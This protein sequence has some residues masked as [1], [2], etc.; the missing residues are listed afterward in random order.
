MPNADGGL[1]ARSGEGFWQRLKPALVRAEGEYS[2]VKGLTILSVF[3]TLIGAYFQNLSA[4]ESKVAAQAQADLTAATQVFAETSSALAAPLSLQKQL[5][6]DYHNAIVAGT[7]GEAS[8]Y[9]TAHAHEI[10]KAYTKAYADLSQNYN[11]LARKAEL[12]IDLASDLRRNPTSDGTPSSDEID[13]SR[14]N[15]YGFDCETHM[16]SFERGAR[17]RNGRQENNSQEN[18]SKVILTDAATK[19]TLTVDWYSAKHQVLAI[20]TCFEITHQA[21][22]PVKQWASGSTVDPA[23]KT[24]FEQKTF[25]VFQTR[26]S[27]QVLRLNAFM[28]LAMFDIEKVR[29]KYRPNGFICSIPG[30]SAVLGLF[31]KCT[32]VRTS[33]PLS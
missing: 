8:A 32:P 1:D 21:M 7:D 16:P 11:L 22:T 4:Y 27:N 20:E 30:L 15:A 9:E 18:N 31:G 12:Y 3:G 17:D 6:A 25:D 13:M 28:S 5:I 19:K 23:E 33:S 2:F 24:R 29:I 14:L 10:Y 26:A